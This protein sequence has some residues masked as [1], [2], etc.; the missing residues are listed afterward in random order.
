MGGGAVLSV[1]VAPDGRTFAAGNSDGSV[2][3][4]ELASGTPI[5]TIGAHSK[6]VFAL[7]YSPDSITLVS[8]ARDGIVRRWRAA[9]GA[10]LSELSGHT[11][12]VFAVAVAPDGARVASGGEDRTVRLWQADVGS[13]L[14]HW[15]VGRSRLRACSPAWVG[16]LGASVRTV[17]DCRFDPGFTPVYAVAFTPD[18]RSIVFADN[19]RV[20][21]ELLP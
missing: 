1:A 18:S 15:D 8:G 4:W 12:R 13:E 14:R 5:Q 3:I 16:S 9:D 19:Q 6:L 10:M 2:R 11:D 20:R 17:T 7:A 21:I